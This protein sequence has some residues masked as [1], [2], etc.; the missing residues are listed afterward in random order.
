VLN[1]NID[2][3]SGTMSRLPPGTYTGTLTIQGQ[4]Q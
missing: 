1:F 3:S 2:L 4:A